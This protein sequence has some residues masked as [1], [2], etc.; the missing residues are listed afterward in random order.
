M[1]ESFDAYVEDKCLDRD[2]YLR[3]L[4]LDGIKHV[5]KKDSVGIR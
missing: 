3:R 4:L 2:K 5:M 1:A